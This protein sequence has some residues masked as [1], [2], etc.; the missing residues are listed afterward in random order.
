[1]R[2]TLNLI[3]CVML[4]LVALSIGAIIIREGSEILANLG[5]YIMDLFHT[6][7]LNPKN[8]GF[9]SFIQ[10]MILACFVGW[11]IRRFKKK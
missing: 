11:T 8:R 9:S 2:Q 5:E 10:L 6:A 4:F 7:D 1:M 3:L